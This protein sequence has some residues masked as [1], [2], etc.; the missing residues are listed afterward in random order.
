MS[1]DSSNQQLYLSKFGMSKPPFATSPD[2]RFF[3]KTESHIDS[4]ARLIY[5]IRERKGF[6]CLTGNVGTG[7]TTILNTLLT[8]LDANV[9]FSHITYS[10]LDFMELL[11]MICADFGLEIEGK[12]KV[13]LM[14]ELFHFVVSLR[15]E[16]K[17]A[18]VIIDEAQNLSDDTLESLRMLSNVETTQ[19]K[20]LQI[21]LCGQPELKEKLQQKRLRQLAQRIVVNI[22]L[23]P[24]NE[25]ETLKYIYGR[26]LTAGTNGETI[27]P[28]EVVNRIAFS[29]GGIPRVI[30]IL[31]DNCL[32]ETFL[33]DCREV[34]TNILHKV[35]NS[36]FGLYG[37]REDDGA[38]DLLTD[39]E[40][41]YEYT[42]P[43]KEEDRESDLME[44][45]NPGT[46]QLSP[47]NLFLL[48]VLAI[49]SI[50]VAGLVIN[51]D[52]LS[53]FSW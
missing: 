23:L 45:Y 5:S 40:D 39:K 10:D 17:N 36:Y 7:K 31:C 20:L 52:L 26:M 9:V 4:L 21:L 30:N 42:P 28:R 32:L 34:T 1:E 47:F 22:E 24:L 11:Q 8:D 29:S 25:E 51:P 48:T 49:M 53:T 44:I 15:L 37:G 12:T 2:P 46:R 13:K 27:F 3:V 19:E 43:G 35:E 6:I 14:N 16:G 33:Q 38:S 41:I 50:I 18:L